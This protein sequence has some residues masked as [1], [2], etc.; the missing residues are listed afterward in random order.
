MMRDARAGYKGADAEK[1]FVDDATFA[2]AV[3]TFFRERLEFC[4]RDVCGY[5]QDVVRAVLAADADDVVDAIKRAHAVQWARSVKDFESVLIAF[6][7]IKNILKQAREKQFE[8]G[9]FE[10]TIATQKELDLY[11]AMESAGGAFAA[12]CKKADYENAIAEIA[13][14]RH[15][16]DAYFDSILVM[17]PDVEIRTSRLGFLQIFYDEFSTIADFSEIVTEGK[18]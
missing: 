3:T 10:R 12:Y 16:V 1:K 14:L 17:D 18:M 4:L 5:A 8:I 11:L 9:P 13:R 15:P 6:K 2:E 7:R